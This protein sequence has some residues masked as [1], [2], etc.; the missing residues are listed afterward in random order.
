DTLAELRANLESEIEAREDTLNRPLSE[1]ELARLLESHGMP[2]L[3]AA[4]YAPQQFL[5]GP[6]LFPFYW[7]TL[8][9]SVPWVVAIYAAI[10][11][12]TVLLQSGSG[13]ELGARIGAA[14]MRLPGVLLTFW[15]VMTLGFAVFEFA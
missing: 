14:A 5:I 1:Q 15:A 13:A 10:S 8:R 3:V 9:R 2:V 6:T 11:G 4:R 12:I 7:Y